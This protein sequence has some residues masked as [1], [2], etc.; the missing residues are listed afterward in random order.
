MR[1]IL[2]FAFV[3]VYLLIGLP[4]L[5]VERII[6]KF[7]KR[8]ADMVTLRYVQWAFRGVLVISGVKMTV[9]GH[10]NVPKEEAV[11]Y[12]GNHRSIFDIV[13][14]YSLCPNLTGY[15]AKASVAKIPVLGLFMK[16]LYCLFMNRTDIKQSLKVILQAIEQVKEGVSMCIFPEGTRNKDKEHPELVLPFKEGSLKIAQ[17]AG[18][19]V[20]PMAIIGTDE[21]F[22]NHLPWIH[23]QNV[24]IIYGEPIVINELEGENKKHPGKYC[25]HI[26]EEMLKK[27]LGI[28]S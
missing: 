18:C 28:R 2:A 5:G 13:T 3:A 1:T 21:I 11:L 16:R 12:V 26:I 9:K 24:T 17:K 6:G 4:F 23:K 25:Q 10:E 19:K 27:E 20:V 15:I 7:N 22:E 8:H 14:T